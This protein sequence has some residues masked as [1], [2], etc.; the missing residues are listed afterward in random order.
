MVG[1]KS[2]GFYVDSR[3]YIFNLHLYIYG[4]V[5]FIDNLFTK[6]FIE[7]YIVFLAS[8]LIIRKN[9]KQTIVI[10]SIIEVEFIN[11]I[12]TV[13][14]IKWIVQIC[15][16]AGYLQRASLF[17]LQELRGA[18]GLRVHPIKF[19]RLLAQI[20]G[21]AERRMHQRC[22]HLTEGGAGANAQAAACDPA[23]PADLISG[24][25]AAS[26]LNRSSFA[27]LNILT[28]NYGNI[29]HVYSS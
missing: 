13:L 25:L 27:T 2:L 14:N 24:R 22:V 20:S 6:V 23:R 9:R 4:D 10:I 8:C 3:Q 1:T 28:H 7:G 17:M 15:I 18:R 26:Q 16:K 21:L 12:S 19:V 29:Y 5:L 11:F